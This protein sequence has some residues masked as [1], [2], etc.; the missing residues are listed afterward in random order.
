MSEQHLMETLA[1]DWCIRI[2]D[3]F[4]VE[5]ADECLRY[6]RNERTV[7]PTRLLFDLTR[8]RLVTTAG[9]GTMLYIK[10]TYQVAD[11]AAIILY[12][13]AAVGEMLRE[14]RIHRLFQLHARAALPVPDRVT[15][16]RGWEWCHA[17]E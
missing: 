1:R 13:D 3:V 17:P 12:Q 15:S 8:T 5:V 10:S 11:D 9:I 6:C 16:A 2:G 4:D 7:P 14:S